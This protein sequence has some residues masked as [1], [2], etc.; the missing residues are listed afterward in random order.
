MSDWGAAAFNPRSIAL[1]GAS[2]KPGKLGYIL[3]RNLLDGYPGTLF[4]VNPGEVEIMGHRSYSLLQD[5][6]GPVDLAVIVLPPEALLQ[7]MRVCSDAPA[8][9]AL[10]PTRY[11]HHHH[12][13]APAH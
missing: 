5:V 6:A 12:P 7:A 2:A 1:I 10:Q 3:M 11:F 13:L 4:P 9:P 8:I